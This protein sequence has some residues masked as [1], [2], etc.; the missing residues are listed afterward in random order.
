MRYGILAIVAWAALSAG[1]TIPT[2]TA[3]GYL[4]DTAER[5][6]SIR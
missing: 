5:I 6:E 2:M 1:V 4:S 3:V